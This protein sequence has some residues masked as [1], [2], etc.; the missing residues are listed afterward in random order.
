MISSGDPGIYGM[1]SLVLQHLAAGDE[2]FVSIVPGVSAV[3]AAAALLGAPLGDDFAVI[4]LSDLLTPWEL[5]ERRS[6]AP[7]PK[8]ISSWRRSTPKRRSDWQLR[9]VREFFA[10]SRLPE[11][12]DWDRSQRLS[13]GTGGG[14]NHLCPD[15]RLRREH[16]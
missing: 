4:S 15:A 7:S 5:I 8:R 11:T 6:A 1:A 2:E 9:P 13:R 10:C 3:N 12:P 14:T 16:V